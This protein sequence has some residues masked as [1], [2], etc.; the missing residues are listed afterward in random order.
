M[1]EA[2][3]DGIRDW[4]RAH[5][6]VVDA[7]LI[8]GLSALAAWLGFGGIWSVFSTLPADVSPWWTMATALPACVL[9]LT[10]QRAPWVSLVVAAVIFAAD[11]FTTGGIGPLVVLLDVLWTAVFV[12]QPRARRRILVVLVASVVVLFIVALIASQ[13]SGATAFHVA[14]QFAAFVGTDYWWAVAV[15]QANE[16]AALHRQR[17]D[18]AAE[19][20]ERE[21]IEAVLREREAM[22]RELHDVVAGHVLAMAIRAE[23]AL[24][25]PPDSSGDRAALQAVR[26]AGLDAHGALRSM[27][28]VLRRGG[29]ELSPTP[30]L[31][32]IA[33]LVD[34]AR[35][36]GLRVR[37]TI[38]VE[39]LPSPVEQAVVRIVREGL[40]NCVR[41]ASGAEVEVRVSRSGT[42]VRVVV[43]SRGGDTIAARAYAGGG[44][45][46]SML[47]ERVDALGGEF[48]AGP[49]GGGWRIDAVIPVE[50]S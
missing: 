37:A 34:D 43:D 50:A 8:A 49:R 44:W 7:V 15:S 13:A 27:I 22:A 14:L 11:L 4:Y 39:G 21:R 20:A 2:T 16:L 1:E 30:S 31:A 38:D 36:A 19:A 10:K 12:A 24:S 9:V 33:D 48:S 46:L 18:E 28:A 45:G 3:A 17:A 29:G 47:A 40:S 32:D 26:D 23:A 42:A 25:T 41:H 5:R 6:P 35:R